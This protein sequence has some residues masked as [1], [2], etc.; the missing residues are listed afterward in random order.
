MRPAPGRRCTS[1]CFGVV[2]PDDG[3]S[4]ELLLWV[5][6]FQPSG[7]S[8][9]SMRAALLGHAGF[10]LPSSRISASLARPPCCQITT[11]GGAVMRSRV[12]P[13]LVDDLDPGF[14]GHGDGIAGT[15]V[16][17]AHGVRHSIAM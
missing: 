13:R 15:Q 11:S 6:G 9:R 5:D 4:H 10:G 1:D 16:D 2:D 8:M 12:T 3:T 14:T 7:H 17:Q